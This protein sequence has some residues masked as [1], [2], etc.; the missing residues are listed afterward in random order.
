MGV[1]WEIWD[2]IG[3]NDINRAYVKA[4]GSGKDLKVDG[5]GW[6]C[7]LSICDSLCLCRFLSRDGVTWGW[8]RDPPKC[9]HQKRF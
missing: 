4:R 6:R 8:V 3:S 1:D 5:M 9:N 2:F 7:P